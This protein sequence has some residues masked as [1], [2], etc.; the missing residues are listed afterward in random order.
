MAMTADQ[1]SPACCP[2]GNGPVIPTF[3]VLKAVLTLALGIV[4]LTLSAEPTA[5]FTRFLI[6]VYAIDT[7]GAYGSRWRSE[8][9]LRYF[10]TENMRM[11]PRPFCFAFECA[12][13]GDIRPGRPSIPFQFLAGYAESAILVHVETGHPCASSTW[14]GIR[15]PRSWST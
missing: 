8:T 12:L 3:T 6:P 11:A 15:S 4:P 1:P 14:L 10:G 13:E 9:W 2:R 7:P 5:G